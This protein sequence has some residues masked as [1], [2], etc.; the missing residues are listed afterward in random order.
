MFWRGGTVCWMTASYGV[1]T[2]ILLPC[3]YSITETYGVPWASIDIQN[4]AGSFVGYSNT[5]LDLSGIQMPRSFSDWS[6][7]TL[8]TAG[9]D[10][11]SYHLLFILYIPHLV[12]PPVDNAV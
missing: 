5:P 10:C 6:K 1:F 8:A 11:F 7:F 12:V 3:R 9:A 4:R 2:R